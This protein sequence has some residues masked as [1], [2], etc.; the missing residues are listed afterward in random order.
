[1]K[2][3]KHSQKFEDLKAPI[4]L[5][6]NIVE[7][8]GFNSLTH[9]IT[10]KPITKQITIEIELN[11]LE[12][13]NKEAQSVD[14]TLK[15]TNRERTSYLQVD[16]LSSQFLT[17]LPDVMGIMSNNVILEAFHQYLGRLSPIMRPY[18][19]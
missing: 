4:H 15:K 3:L 19:R 18:T 10:Y 11:R 12:I 13:F 2:S 1:M 7:S 17:A 6:N 5:L 8:A 16:K 9:K 14:A